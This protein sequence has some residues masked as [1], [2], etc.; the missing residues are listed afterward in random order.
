MFP[1]DFEPNTPAP[2]TTDKPEVAVTE[3]GSASAL[4]LSLA[5]YVS[6]DD[7]GLDR[8]EFLRSVAARILYDLGI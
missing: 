7:V 4:V 1:P 8:K 3:L 6:A 5:P 2:A